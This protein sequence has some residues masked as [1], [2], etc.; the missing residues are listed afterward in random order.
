MTMRLSLS[1]NAYVTLVSVYAPTITNEDENKAAF[2]QQLDE[3]G[4]SVPAGDQL[5][6][7]GV[8]GGGGGISTLE[9]VQIIRH[10]LALLVKM[11]LVMK[12][13][14][15]NFYFH[16]APSTIAQSQTHSSN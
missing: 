16:C 10:G 14:M 15:E 8:G 5:I 2:Y 4:R 12:T 9:S 13:Q 6:T 7:P 11:V 1:D 3:V